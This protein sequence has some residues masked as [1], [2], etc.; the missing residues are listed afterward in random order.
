MR[1]TGITITNLD[2]SLMEHDSSHPVT[3]WENIEKKDI[4]C[5]RDW[6]VSS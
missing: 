5:P 3:G 2:V 6:R 1:V 4:G